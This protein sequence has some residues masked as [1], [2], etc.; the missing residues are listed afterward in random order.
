ML[1]KYEED[2][3]PGSYSVSLRQETG[4]SFTK[5]AK[6]AGRSQ[7]PDLLPGPG[8]YYVALK[9]LH[10]ETAPSLTPRRV[11]PSVSAAELP[12][13]GAYSSQPRSVSPAYSIG[14]S[15]KAQLPR[16]LTPSPADYS[17][18][19]LLRTT[20]GCIIGASK[21]DIGNRAGDLPGPGAYSPVQQAR[22][23]KFSMKMR[24]GTVSALSATP[25][26]AS[27]GPGAYN[28]ASF[29]KAYTAVIG[30]EPKLA[31]AKETQR[32]PP[33][34]YHIN[35][36]LGSQ[37]FSFCKSTRNKVKQSDCPGPGAYSLP[38]AVANVPTYL[39]SK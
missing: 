19:L 7:T 22:S 34:S 37:G 38:S 36:D 5:A 12:G 8:A 39:L 35:R 20:P 29:S 6:T 21:R 16:S 13:P 18:H 32:P 27:Q 3:G 25:V 33:G 28:P 9:V 10:P 15:S 26:S 2:P 23:P 4:F 14:R 17:P 11:P 31:T 1:Q 30:S 24:L